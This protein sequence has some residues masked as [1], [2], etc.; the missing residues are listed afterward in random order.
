MASGPY[1]Q[2]PVFATKAS[3]PSGPASLALHVHDQNLTIPASASLY[4]T[5]EEGTG[6]DGWGVVVA[7]LAVVEGD[8]ERRR[9]FR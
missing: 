7:K 6:S 1:V 5:T 2:R 3:E 4:Q 8:Y 9:S